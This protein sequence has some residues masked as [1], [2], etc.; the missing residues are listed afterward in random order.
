MLISASIDSESSYEQRVVI[1]E[2]GA[3]LPGRR[4]LQ[5]GLTTFVTFLEPALAAA[6]SYGQEVSLILHHVL[7]ESLSIH[8]AH[9]LSEM[10]KL[11]RIEHC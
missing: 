6:T 4:P 2:M 9:R 1:T 11:Q 3:K 10:E 7:V 5:K 8:S